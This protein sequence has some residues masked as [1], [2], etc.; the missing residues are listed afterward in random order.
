MSKT[1]ELDR[2][3]LRQ[4]IALTEK[5][6]NFRCTK[7]PDREECEGCIEEGCNSKRIT[8]TCDGKTLTMFTAALQE[9]GIVEADIQKYCDYSIDHGGYCDCEVIFNVK[10]HF[11][12]GEKKEQKRKARDEQRP[13]NV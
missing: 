5:A 13:D 10:E 12:R 6:C 9:L 8:W 4:A 7:Y 11:E 2:D 3:I 1:L